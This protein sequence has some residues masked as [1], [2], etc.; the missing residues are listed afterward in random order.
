[1]AARVI[2]RRVPSD[3]PWLVRLRE[4]G[5]PYAW[6]IERA[7]WCPARRIEPDPDDGLV[8]LQTI[9][10]NV[11]KQRSAHADEREHRT[12]QL[13]ARSDGDDAY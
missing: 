3:A 2:A 13:L 12:R 6:A 10:D 9:L 1:M 8:T 11:S 5:D 4:A 7:R